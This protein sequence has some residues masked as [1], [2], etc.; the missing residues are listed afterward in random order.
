MS[1]KSLRAVTAKAVKDYNHGIVK[2]NANTLKHKIAFDSPQLTY[3]FGGF[4]YDRIHQAFGPESSGKSSIYTYIAG[5]LQKKMP[6]EIER[7]AKAA[8]DDGDTE[9]AAKIR[10]DFAD[11]QVVIY[12]DYERTFDPEYAVALGLNCDEDHFILIQ[13]DSLEDGFNMIDP[14]VK[15]GSI[16]CVIFDS[17]AAAPTNLDNE[18]E[19]GSTGFN[20]AKGA[21][22]LKEVYKHFNILASNYLTPLLVVSQERANMNVMSHLP[23]QTGGTAIK[24]FSSTRNRITKIDELKDT[25]GND[26]GIQ[27]RVRNYKNKTGTPWRDAIMNLYF[28]RG[29]DSDAEYFDFLSEFGLITKGNGGVYSA[30]FWNESTGVP[31]GKIRGAA[32]A[33]AWFQDP[34]HRD[35][36]EQLKVKVNEKLMSKNELDADTVDPEKNEIA[37]IAKEKNMSAEKLAEEA[38]KA[39]NAEKALEQEVIENP[40]EETPPDLG[41]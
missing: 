25:N 13:A 36:Y 16:C 41:L 21:N 26:A 33:L 39:A 32:N 29:F 23:S 14:M 4:S 30:D 35:I 7:L 15:S 22:T 6:E 19:V 3:M 20:G 5:Q 1:L 27:I 11:K 24:F 34:A 12:L 40:G 37:E 28:D 8:E 10:T 2:A 18:S 17:D 31:T 9:K 38:L